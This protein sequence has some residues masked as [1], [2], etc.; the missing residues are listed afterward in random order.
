MNE[1]MSTA[2][3]DLKIVTAWLLSISRDKSL[4]YHPGDPDPR[5][6]IVVIELGELGQYPPG[7]MLNGVLEVVPDGAS[8][9]IFTV[10]GELVADIQPVN[11]RA[12]WGGRNKQGQRV[13]PGT[14]LYL[15]QKGK[16]TLKAGKIILVRGP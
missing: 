3:D 8:L 10:S 15:I 12:E 13:A 5:D 16:E 4:L 7:C 1:N 2:L 11:G 9:K 6:R 14:Y